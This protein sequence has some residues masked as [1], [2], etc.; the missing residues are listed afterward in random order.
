MSEYTAEVTKWT[1]LDDVVEERSHIGRLHSD[2]GITF[3]FRQDGY[4]MHSAEDA[5]NPPRRLRLFTRDAKLVAFSHLKDA[6]AI[7]KAIHKAIRE[8]H[9]LCRGI[10]DA[11]GDPTQYRIEIEPDRVLFRASCELNEELT[12]YQRRPDGSVEVGAANE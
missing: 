9:T 10:R 1:T 11:N 5:D 6:P 7:R 12:V 8:A 3:Q 2:D 4:G